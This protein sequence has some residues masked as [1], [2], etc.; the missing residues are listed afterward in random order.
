MRLTCGLSK[1]AHS[2]EALTSAP[3][4]PAPHAP[5]TAAKEEYHG[6]CANFSVNMSAAEFGSCMCGFKKQDHGK[7]REQ[8]M[9]ESQLSQAAANKVPVPPPQ[10][11]PAAAAPVVVAAPAKEVAATS[12]CSSYS[13]DVN[14]AK[15]GN[16]KCGFSKDAHKSAGTYV[17]PEHKVFAGGHNTEPLRATAVASKLKHPGKQPKPCRDYQ[18]DMAGKIFGDCLCGHAKMQHRQFNASLGEEEEEQ[19]EAPAPVIIVR[20]GVHPCEV[21]ELDLKNAG[22]FANCLCG[23]TRLDHE[24]FTNDPSEWLKVKESLTAPKEFS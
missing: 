12:P 9:S 14:G 5:A 16:C 7:P 18:V 4:A 20:D 3:P 6:P 13:V 2:K 17:E 10:P 21:F 8:F 11:A 22:G 15:F 23:F 1:L 24:Q 19:V